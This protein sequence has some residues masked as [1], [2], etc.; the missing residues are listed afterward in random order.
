MRICQASIFGTSL[1]T[2]G[3]TSAPFPSSRT[4]RANDGASSPIWSK[5]VTDTPLV[6]MTDASA[7]PCD[8]CGDGGS[9]RASGDQLGMVGVRN[10]TT[11][12]RGMVLRRRTRRMDMRGR[13]VSIWT[14][15][16]KGDL[17][18]CV[19]RVV[20]AKPTM[21]A[22]GRHALD[23]AHGRMQPTGD[24]EKRTAHNTAC[25]SRRVARNS[26]KRKTVKQVVNHQIGL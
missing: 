20:P 3:S 12:S 21:V 16:T 23:S 24:T 1:E 17:A 6:T 8:P 10:R 22:K 18:L 15:G 2:R 26:S 9:A 11:A 7:R 13:P 25:I 14:Q 5:R 4:R 19:W